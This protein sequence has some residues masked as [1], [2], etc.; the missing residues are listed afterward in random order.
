MFTNGDTYTRFGKFLRMTKLD[1]LPQLWNVL[2]GDLA[3]VGPRAEEERTSQIIPQHL[4]DIILSVKPGITSPASIHF[5]DE[6]K[7]L[8]ASKDP[9]GVY[10]TTVKPMKLLLD[11]WY[12]QH[13]GFLLDLSLIW[14]TLRTIVIGR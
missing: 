11:V 3:L 6:E 7:T 13:R 14:T 12:V 5:Y 9:T 10:W 2:R 4:R 1:E 8:Q